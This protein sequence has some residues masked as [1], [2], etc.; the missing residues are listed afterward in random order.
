MG[1]IKAGVTLMQDFCRPESNEFGGYVDYL[2]GDHA[3]KTNITTYDLYGYNDYMGNPEKSSGLF[4]SAKDEL[5]YSDKKEIKELFET[6]QANGSLMWQTVISFDNR[7]L[8]N[9]GLFDREN[10][11]LDE[12]KIKEVIRVGVNRMLKKEGLEFAVWSGGIHYNTDNI[13]VHIATV[14]PEPTRPKMKYQGVEQYRGKFKQKSIELCKSS[15]VNEIVMSRD[16]N[17]KINNI[18]RKNI[19]ASKK[20][21]LLS[22]DPEIRKDFLQLYES[23]QSVPRNMQNYNN[24]IM[25]PYR[26]LID[27]ISKK[28]IEKYHKEDYEHLE[29][30]LEKQGRMYEQAYGRSADLNRNYVTAKERELLERLGNAVLKETKTFEVSMENTEVLNLAPEE[31]E[32]LSIERVENIEP[33]FE[34]LQAEQTEKDSNEMYVLNLAPENLSEK[35]Q[36]ENGV[37]LHS[38]RGSETGSLSEQEKYKKWFME[39]KKAKQY[40][41]RE[42]SKEIE[43]DFIRAKNEFERAYEGG[44][45]LAAYGLG[46]MYLFGRGVEIDTERA[47]LYFRESLTAFQKSITNLPDQ[48]EGNFD[49]KAYLQYRVGK[50]FSRGYGTE[51]N[52]Q[53][54]ATYFEKSNTSYAKFSLA[55]LYYNGDGVEKDYEK[56]FKLYKEASDDLSQRM[57]YADLKVAKMYENGIGTV[58][59]A[60][61]SEKYYKRAFEGFM[62]EEN[63]QPDHQIEYQLGTML[64]SGKGCERNVSKG[65]AYLENAAK[66]KNIYAQYKLSTIYIKEGDQE[67]IRKAIEW[68]E[69][70]AISGKHSMAQYSLGMLYVDQD[71]TEYNLQKGIDYLKMSAEQDNEYAQYQLGKIYINPSNQGWDLGLGIQY[72]NQAAEHDNEYAQYQLGKIHIDSKSEYYDMGLGIQFLKQA[73]EKGNEYAE[74]QLGKIYID[75]KSEYYDMGLGIQYLEQAAEKGNKYA[76]YQLGKVYINPLNSCYDV[77]LGIQYLER[78]YAQGNQYAKYQLGKEYLNKESAAYEPKKGMQYMQELGENGFEYAQMK[79]G[80]EYMKGVS[81]KRDLEQARQWFTKAAEQGNIQALSMLDNLSVYSSGRRRGASELDKALSSLKRSMQKEYINTMKNIREYE[82]DLNRH[83]NIDEIEL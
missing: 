50:Q 67:N 3:N 59:D 37:F 53:V 77:K 52:N 19:V 34:I 38:R 33:D 72:L 75:S 5:S 60:A 51:K 62:V 39:N 81:V 4:T 30:I 22:N 64:Y 15:I 68:L 46:E 63:K 26:R 82:Y 24:N 31:T 48:S 78:S 29:E 73:A 79:L 23:I 28:Y 40:L 49:L 42:M 54:A 71:G 66:Q 74:Y 21:H 7:W 44:N 17:L 2:D 56:A 18:I 16:I 55:G 11:I 32:V 58:A 9:N 65:I 8:E 80:Y 25:R 6:A 47:E 12:R 13:H 1:E 35:E 70:L 61:L 76:E 83:R 41:V 36:R 14:E 43:P 27:S 10:Q 69:E 45:P 57:P 20:E